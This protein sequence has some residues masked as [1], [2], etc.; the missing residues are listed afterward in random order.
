MSTTPAPAFTWQSLLGVIE[1]AGNTI[2]SVLVPGG[3]AM[4]SLLAS[5]EN[6]VNPLLQSIG[7]KPSVTNEVMTVYG[8]LIGVLTVLKNQPGLPAATLALVDSYLIAAQNG[9]ASYLL[10]AQGFNPAQFQPVAPIA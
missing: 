4:A 7:T 5:L 3:A 10:A 2:V 8:T 6:A 1:L 9:T